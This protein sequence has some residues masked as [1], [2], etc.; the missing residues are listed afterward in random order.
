MPRFG[1]FELIATCGRCDS[2]V[3]VNAPTRSLRCGSCGESVHLPPEIIAGLINDF[4]EEHPELQRGHGSGGTLISGSGRYV[5][6]YWRLRPR[7]GV[8]E[9][10]LDTASVAPGD[11][12]ICRE[13][14]EAYAYLHPPEWLTAEAPAVSACVCR[15]RFVDAPEAAGG[16]TPD[17]ESPVAMG[18]PQCGGF[19]ELDMSAGR[20]QRCGYCGEDVRIPDG[21]W[22][23]LRPPVK[24]REW[25]C[26]LDGP[27][28]AQRR[29]ERRRGD[30]EEQKAEMR[31]RTP[32]PLRSARASG[33]L[34]RTFRFIA[35]AALVPLFTALAA[36]AAG[37]SATQAVPIMSLSVGTV[38][39]GLIMV[40]AFSC[41]ISYRWGWAGKCKERMTELAAE[42]GWEHSGSHHRSC[43]GRIGSDVGG[44]EFR[45]HPGEEYAVEVDQD[46]PGLYL[47]TEAP[48]WP[49]DGLVRF[50][51]GDPGFDRLFPVRYA[52]PRLADAIES[53]P[54]KILE[55][56]GPFLSRWEGALARFR[57]DWS[58]ME[59]HLAPGHEKSPRWLYPEEIEPLLYSM[60]DL[61]KRV[62]RVSDRS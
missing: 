13:C 14:G 21:L 31:R 60:M 19:L 34:G 46:S 5:Y 56:F 48:A 16:E 2:P 35:L 58:S 9:T 1:C 42:R 45:L 23:R 33:A 38:I 39:L 62:E 3:P 47:K 44:R 59:A 50:T 25:F 17:G 49:P 26:I 41:S 30:L 53:S 27:T 4:D 8:C 29:M 54:G 55:P 51:T 12:L 15:H 28:L 18:C 7:C 61:A 43:M 52:D 11:P 57:L 20:M 37:A 40:P 6:S 10:A 22:H 24:A 36:I 32:P